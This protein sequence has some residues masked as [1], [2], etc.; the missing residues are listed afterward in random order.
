MINKPIRYFFC[1][2]VS[3]IYM[4]EVLF[5]VKK[6]PILAQNKLYLQ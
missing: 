1:G 2:L 3:V 4:L 6:T 5:F